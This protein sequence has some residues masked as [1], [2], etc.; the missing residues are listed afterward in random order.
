MGSMSVCKT[1]MKRAEPL[2]IL[3]VQRRLVDS[4]DEVSDSGS[5]IIVDTDGTSESKPGF[6]PKKTYPLAWVGLVC[7]FRAGYDVEENKRLF[8]RF[9]KDGK[10]PA[11]HSRAVSAAEKDIM[12]MYEAGT[13][14]TGVG[15]NDKASERLAFWSDQGIELLDLF[16]ATFLEKIG[17]INKVQRK[18]INQSDKYYREWTGELVCKNCRARTA[19]GEADVRCMSKAY[20]SQC[21]NCAMSGS[22][23]LPVSGLE[24]NLPS[25]PCSFQLTA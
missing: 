23:D 14:R 18:T 21:S 1:A 19:Q 25:N 13:W 7:I 6:P 16:T 22:C 20:N 5:T 10:A 4:D 2:L 24:L 3:V 8:K 17:V 11:A 12:V 15:K 9:Q